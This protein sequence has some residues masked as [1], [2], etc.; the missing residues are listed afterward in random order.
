MYSFDQNL[1][2]P[3]GHI[4]IQ[5]YI[6]PLL[7]HVPTLLVHVIEFCKMDYISLMEIKV[8]TNFKIIYGML[9]TFKHGIPP[10]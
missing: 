4:G 2:L 8:N 10:T 6:V 7:S 1:E 5:T 3:W 9:T